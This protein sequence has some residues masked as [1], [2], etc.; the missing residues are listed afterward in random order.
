MRRNSKNKN[1][2]IPSKEYYLIV[3]VDDSGVKQGLSKK[4]KRIYVTINAFV[5]SIN[6]ARRRFLR[7]K[8]LLLEYDKK[9]QDSNMITDGQC[10]IS[11]GCPFR[12]EIVSLAWDV[13][14]WLERSRK[15][16][17]SLAGIPKKDQRY[18]SVMNALLPATKYRHMLQHY[19]SDVITTLVKNTFPLMGAVLAAYSDEKHNYGRVIIST[20]ARYAGDQTISIAGAK[21]IAAH[22]KSPIGSITLSLANATINLSVLF[23]ELDSCTNDIREIL[24]QTYDYD[25]SSVDDEFM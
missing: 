6:E 25:W 2:A 3:K 15:I 13:V 21:A 5:F 18:V 14:D 16:F 22:A 1:S 17:G 19:D 24:K 11:L 12:N 20:P 23:E 4:G 7:I 8:N 9:E 10:S